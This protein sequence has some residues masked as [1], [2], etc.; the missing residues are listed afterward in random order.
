MEEY[1]TLRWTQGD[2]YCDFSPLQTFDKLNLFIWHLKTKLYYYTDA[3]NDHAYKIAYIRL[4]FSHR[5]NYDYLM[6]ISPFITRKIWPLSALEK[7]Y[8]FIHYADI[9]KLMTKASSGI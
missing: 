1:H 5:P 8:Y 2:K 6:T 3:I 9:P 7:R 4:D